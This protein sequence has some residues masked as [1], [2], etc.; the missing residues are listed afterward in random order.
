MKFGT[1]NEYFQDWPLEQVFDYAA[2]IGYDGVE[3][4]PFT[5]APSVEEIGTG[6]RREIRDAAAAVGVEIIG[7]HWL[8]LSPEGL[9]INHP[10]EAI[11]GRTHD[12][13][14]SLIHFCGDLGGQVMVIGSPKQRNVQEGWNFDDCWKRARDSFAGC[15]ELAAERDVVLCIEALSRK[16]TNFLDSPAAALRMVAEIDHPNFRT[17]VDVCSGS[18]FATPVVEQLVEADA[19]SHLYHV[20]VND[21]NMR[22]PGFGDTDFASILRKLRE[23][24]YQRYVSVEVFDF[25]P[26]PRTIAAASLAYMR[27]I[28]AGQA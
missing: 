23:L 12:Y 15:A 8:L 21:A 13:V 7:L 3:I 25:E 17:M 5:I 28:A 9:Y 1:C 24:D 11:R 14:R 4:A 27:G 19:N 26:D 16:Q 18:T 20:H 10:D 2:A 22:G 6:R